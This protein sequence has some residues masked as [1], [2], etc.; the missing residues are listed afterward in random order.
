M[1]K[2]GKV[3]RDTTAGPGLLVIEGRQFTFTLE[4]L[5][6]SDVAPRPGLIVEAE[7]DATG[8]RLTSITAVPESQVAKEQAELALAAAKEKG[9]AL[10]ATAVAKF[11]A[12]AL[13]AAGAL[14][15]GWFFLNSVVVTTPLG[16]LEFTFWNILGLLHSGRDLESLMGRM[17]GR[18][19]STGFYGF[20]A[21][22]ALAGPFVHH[23]WRDKRAHLAGLLPLGLMLF[24]VVT[25]YTTIHSGMGQANEAAV[26]FGGGEGQ[27]MM[28]QMADSWMKEIMAAISIGLGA[29]LSFV[30][31]VYFAGVSAKQ[32]L[33]ARASA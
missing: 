28:N 31:S 2:R 32:Y 19:G 24:V 9:A 26:A 27:Q 30:A 18:G 3:L 33:V 22:A 4:G 25:I 20:L 8:D 13:A 14:I 29:Y 21:L 11:G 23:F 16:K 10:A 5:W 12:P 1:K 17:S 7:L 6:K 15:L